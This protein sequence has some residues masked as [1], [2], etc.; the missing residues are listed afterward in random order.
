MA[1]VVGEGALHREA[2]IGTNREGHRCL[3][4]EAHCRRGLSKPQGG[5]YHGRPCGL[6]RSPWVHSLR[7]TCGMVSLCWQCEGQDCAADFA[8]EAEV[9]RCVELIRTR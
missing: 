2:T 3:A 4:G 8:L 5:A 9:R 7:Y 1:R 6:T